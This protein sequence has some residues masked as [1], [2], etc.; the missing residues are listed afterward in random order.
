ML[1]QVSGPLI[2]GVLADRTG[3]YE[4]GFTILAGLAA[5]GSVFFILATKPQPKAVAGAARVR[6]AAGAPGD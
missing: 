2:A 5:F 1:G 3:S 6:E 4:S